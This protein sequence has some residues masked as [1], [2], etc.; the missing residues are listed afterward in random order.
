[1][2]PRS[3]RIG[4]EC[5]GRK[6]GKPMQGSVGQCY[7]TGLLKSLRI[8]KNLKCFFPVTYKL[9][10]NEQGSSYS[11]L[12]HCVGREMLREGMRSP[13]NRSEQRL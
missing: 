10:M 8:F 6:E 1:M 2:T 5:K 11:T 9:Y 7:R 4:T 3:D 13:W 12:D